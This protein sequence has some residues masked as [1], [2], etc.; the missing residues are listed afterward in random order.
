MAS[1]EAVG[2]GYENSC[3]IIHASALIAAAIAGVA[4]IA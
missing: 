1:D 4:K 2:T 3:S